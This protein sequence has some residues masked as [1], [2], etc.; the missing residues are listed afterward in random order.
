MTGVAPIFA[1]KPDP[2]VIDEGEAKIFVGSA[3]GVTTTDA[4]NLFA[5]LHKMEF[6]V[7]VK[8][9]FPLLYP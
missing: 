9:P 8:I 7:N 3:I 4:L 5:L 6:H 1:L 2:Q